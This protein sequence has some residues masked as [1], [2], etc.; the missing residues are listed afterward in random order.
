MK[1]NGRTFYLWSVS[2][3]KHENAWWVR[4]KSHFEPHE[5]YSVLS[6]QFHTNTTHFNLVHDDTEMSFHHIGDLLFLSLSLIKGQW[7]HLSCYSKKSCPLL[8]LS[9]HPLLRIAISINYQRQ[10]LYPLTLS[11]N[12]SWSLQQH[13]APWCAVCSWTTTPMIP[14]ASL[15]WLERPMW[16]RGCCETPA[17]NGITHH[18]LKIDAQLYLLWDSRKD[19][20]LISQQNKVRKD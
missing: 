19:R 14:S 11:C 12:G 8:L 5:V 1:S 10:I 4:H 6:Q 3:L 17:P 2:K 9:S 20:T 18:F 15:I 16:L 7:V 13:F